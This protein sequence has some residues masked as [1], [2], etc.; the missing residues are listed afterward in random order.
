MN[1]P[2]FSHKTDKKTIGES[3][4]LLFSILRTRISVNMCKRGGKRVIYHFL[5]FKFFD[6]LLHGFVEKTMS[7]TLDLSC[8]IGIHILDVLHACE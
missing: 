7:N 8:D 4:L 6:R 1:G 5:A 3:L 2:V